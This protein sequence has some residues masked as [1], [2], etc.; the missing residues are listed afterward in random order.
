MDSRIQRR[1]YLF[2]R[3]L[4]DSF[5]ALVVVRSRDPEILKTLD[6]LVD[7]GAEYGILSHQNIV[8]DFFRPYIKDPSRHRYDHHQR[9]F[10]ETMEIDGHRFETKLSSAGLIYRYPSL[11]G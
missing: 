2:M 10:T 6:I 5:N 11:H 3:I 4:L 8:I 7:V 1:G 9:G